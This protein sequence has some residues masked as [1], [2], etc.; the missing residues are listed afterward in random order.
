MRLPVWLCTAL[1][2]FGAAPLHGQ[3]RLAPI[4]FGVAFS[5]GSPQGGLADVAEAPKG[6]VAQLSVPVDR[7]AQVGIRAEFSILTFPERSLQVATGESGATA[8]V[9]VR[10]TVG[11]TGAGPRMEMRRGRFAAALGAMAGFIR[12]I[13]DATARVDSDGE[14]SGASISLSDYAFAAKASADLHLGVYCG[15]ANT[16]VG[17]VGGVDYMTGSKV[18]FPQVS[19]LRVTAPGELA[20]DRPAVTPSMV[21]LRVGVGVEF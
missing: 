1:V 3:A 21:G 18:A 11:F 2:A 14:R 13:T 7:T 19:S 10:G 4:R 20:L 17:V 16:C 12:V 6:F 15:V 9:T 5:Q 8:D